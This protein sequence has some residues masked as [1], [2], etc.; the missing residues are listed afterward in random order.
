MSGDEIRF[1]PLSATII[2]SA[3]IEE[4][5]KNQKALLDQRNVKR[6]YV[7]LETHLSLNE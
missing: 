7:V 1:V 6:S 5:R 2:I 3:K 4:I